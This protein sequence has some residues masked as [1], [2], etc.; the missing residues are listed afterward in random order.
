M[1]HRIQE[2]KEVTPEL[3]VLSRG[4]AMVQ[5][6]GALL[7]G[8]KRFHGW[9][10]D[11]SLGEAFKDPESGQQKNAGGF[12]KHPDVVVTI[13]ADSPHMTEYRRHV[14]EGDL[15]A[16]DPETAAA[17]G[18]AFEP[19]FGGEH[20]ANSAKH[21]KPATAKPATQATSDGTRVPSADETETK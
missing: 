10:H 19:D 6:Y 7:G 9:R 3:R 8:M 12:V 13:P 2:P 11:A 15:W 1:A 4:V 16:A 21:A 14:R 5:D 17:C 18:V 20:P